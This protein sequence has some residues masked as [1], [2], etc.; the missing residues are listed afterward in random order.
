MPY[1]SESDLKYISGL[2]AIPLTGP[3]AWSDTPQEKLKAADAAEGLLEARVNSGLPLDDVESIHRTAAT[4]Y[5]SY[6]LLSGV[7]HPNSARSG[8]FYSGS[9]EDVAEVAS[10]MKTIWE[11]AVQGIINASADEGTNT[12]TLNVPDF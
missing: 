8:D 3:D 10:E 6:I 2:D 9:N 12:A 7:E 11:D 1:E 4:A 5:A